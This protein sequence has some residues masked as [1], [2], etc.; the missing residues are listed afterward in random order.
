[1]SLRMTRAER[2]SFLA[3]VHVGVVSIPRADAAP[4]TLPI[5]YD[6]RPGGPLWIIT[7]R[8]SAKGKLLEIGTPITLC[9]QS[10]PLPYKYVSVTTR[11]SAIEPA[12]QEKDLRPMARRY[13]GDELGDA[14][15]EQSGIEGQVRVALEPLAWQSEDYAKR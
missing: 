4:L 5:W 12:D 15:T 11:V 3:G 6:Y 8:T 9:A 2:E 10:E 14:Y 1:M 13:L 7:G